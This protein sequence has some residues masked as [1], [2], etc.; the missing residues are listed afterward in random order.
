MVN[1]GKSQEMLYVFDSVK[2]HC[3]GNTQYILTGYIKN[4]QG[5]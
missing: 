4:L 5:K 3:Q 2:S 1:V